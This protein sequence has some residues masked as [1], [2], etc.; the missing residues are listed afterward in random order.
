LHNI[1][2][3]NDEEDISRNYNITE[4][5]LVIM[6]DNLD[7]TAETPFLLMKGNPG[8]DQS[9]FS[10]RDYVWYCD[11]STDAPL[12]SIDKMMDV[13]NFTDYWIGTIYLGKTTSAHNQMYWR[14][15]T[16]EG[17]NTSQLGHDGRWRWTA[18]DFDNAMFWDTL[19][20]FNVAPYY[21][22][23]DILIHLWEFE[24]YRKRFVDRFCD[25]VNSSFVPDRIVQRIDEFQDRIAPAM[26]YHIDRW[27]TPRSIADWEVG[28]DG[29]R[30]YAH[31]R[32]AHALTHMQQKFAL[33][34]SYNLTLNISEQGAGYVGVNSL[35]IKEDLPGVDS[36][37][38]YPW[39]GTYFTSVPVTITAYPLPGYVFDHWLETG[40]TLAKIIVD[41]AT[42]INRTAVFSK[43]NQP[44]P[45]FV[46]LYPNP[47][48][49]GESVRLNQSC[50]F[51]IYSSDGRECM[52]EQ[53]AVE[54][55]TVKLS[56]GSY[57]IRIVGGA[58][59]RL[60]VVR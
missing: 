59:D 32:P 5:S 20:N 50:E 16:P 7:K 39:T 28:M 14:I 36:L 53:N 56:P 40:D 11:K 3:V 44:E 34:G 27:R 26:Q 60:I 15:R 25:L 13:D 30:D 46:A 55:S 17:L 8:D 58:V 24:G 48:K 41:A 19:D 49:W 21:V 35:L 4:D 51:Y 33:P 1:R 42:S 18:F 22:Y 38:L 23:D 54:F 6:E 10:M 12:D 43:E 37:N 45:T 29:M 57:Y 2:E 31:N 47:V 9:F 52:H